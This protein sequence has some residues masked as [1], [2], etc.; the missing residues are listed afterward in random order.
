MTQQDWHLLGKETLF[1][2]ERV[3]I[4]NWRLQTHH[5]EVKDFTIKIGSDIV[6]VFGITAKKEVVAIKEYF[7]ANQKKIWSLVGGI[8]ENGDHRKT[9][10]NELMEETGCRATEFVLLSTLVKGKYESSVVYN[11]L[12]L[13]AE[14]V[15]EQKLEDSEDIEVE[16]IPLPE[17]RKLLTSGKIECVFEVACAYQALEYLNLL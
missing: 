14:R 12:A 16:I 1:Q 9:A 17:F 7:P 4:E 8:I 11:Y 13:D 10:E 3:L 15:A 6:I 5:G 2:N